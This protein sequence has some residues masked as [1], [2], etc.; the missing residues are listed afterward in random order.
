MTSA[1]P[2][3]ISQLAPLRVKNPSDE[4]DLGNNKSIIRHILQYQIENNR[5]GRLLGDFLTIGPSAIKVFRNWPRAAKENEEI[6]YDPWVS[7]HK[8]TRERILGPKP[9]FTD[10]LELDERANIP[11]RIYRHHRPEFHQL[12]LAQARKVGIEVEYG[13]R[14]IEYLEDAAAR[15]AGGG[16]LEADLVVAADGAGTKSYIL[17][18]GEQVDAKG[19]GYAIYRTAYPIELALA[20]PQVAEHFKLLENGRSVF[21]LW[22]G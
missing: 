15:K 5:F 22:M 1:R 14:V 11:Q 19:S 20:D 16:K 2:V 10:D 13:Q 21:E 12:L 17:T 8:H 4:T 9:I 3:E 18:M 6:S 7:Y